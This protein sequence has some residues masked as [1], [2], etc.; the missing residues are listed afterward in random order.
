MIIRKAARPRGWTTMPNA[1]LEDGRISFKARGLLAYLVSRPDDWE[2]DSIRLSRS[3]H[4]QVDGRDAI[5]AGLT[6][7][8]KLGYLVRHKHQGPGGRWATSVFV[9][10]ESQLGAPELD[11][12]PDQGPDDPAPALAAAAAPAAPEAVHNPVEEM[13]T[14]PPPRTGYPAS[15]NPALLTKNNNHKN[16]TA[17]SAVGGPMEAPVENSPSGLEED[18]AGGDAALLAAGAAVSRSALGEGPELALGHSD[19]IAIRAAGALEPGIQMFALRAHLVAA[20]KRPVDFTEALSYLE[21]AA[22]IAADEGEALTL[23]DVVLHAM[24]A[25]LDP[26]AQDRSADLDRSG[27]RPALSHA[28]FA[29]E[30]GLRPGADEASLAKVPDV[31]QPQKGPHNA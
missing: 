3:L 16:S 18:V 31:G 4:A 28:G 11:L 29:V 26:K 17:H 19:R 24:F 23:P 12:G 10:D 30:A 27:L 21:P 5:R 6:E 14:T 13:W 20:L 22:A 2:T 25:Q 7:L 15:V 8:E 1:T 9:Y